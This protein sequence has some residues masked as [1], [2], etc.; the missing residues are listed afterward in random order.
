V[1]TAT[2][3]LLS[4]SHHGRVPTEAGWAK[5]AGAAPIEASSGQ[6]QKFRLNRRGDRQLN[7]ALHTVATV[8]AQHDP[9][10]RAYLDRKIADPGG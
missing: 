9:T 5:L 4:Y 2:Q 6:N 8:R 7:R 10:T 1:W 3:L